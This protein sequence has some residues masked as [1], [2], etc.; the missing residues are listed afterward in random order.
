MPCDTIREVKVDAGKFQK[1]YLL[2]ALKDLGL[3]PEEH[4]NGTITFGRG[5][6]YNPATGQITQSYGSGT[7]VEKIKQS[8]AAAIVQAQAKRFGWQLKK[9]AG[10][11]FEVLKR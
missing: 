7:P 9:T 2:A 1:E 8:Y 4:K 10:N 3:E 5:E 11:K 6:K